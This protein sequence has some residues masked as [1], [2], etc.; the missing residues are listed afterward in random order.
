[1]RS[2][3]QR[4]AESILVGE[5]SKSAVRIPRDRALKIARFVIEKLGLI[6][7][8]PSKVGGDFGWRD[9][10]GI[11]TGSIRRG[12]ADV[13]DV[14]IL[15]T[16]DV[17]SERDIVRKFG[18]TADGIVSGKKQTFFRYVTED[19]GINIWLCSDPK[20]F[21]AFLAHTTGP[22]DYNI[23]LRSIVKRSGGRAN[24]YGVHDKDG[25]KLDGDT[26]ASFY[27]AIRTSKHPEGLPWKEPSQRSGFGRR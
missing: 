13:G 14:D 23:M 9:N 25:N 15:V 8:D 16:R 1:M 10:I 17:A 5:M 7:V 19:V 21:G 11:P 6:Y 12:K 18:S 24:Q 3:F 2:R 4:L 26:E 20:T 22:N 27:R